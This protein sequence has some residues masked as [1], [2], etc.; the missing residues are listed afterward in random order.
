MNLISYAFLHRE[1]CPICEASNSQRLFEERFTEGETWRFICEYYSDR[2]PREALGK[3]VFTVS[4]CSDCGFVYQE[5]I[6]DNEGMR[7]LYEEWI[8]PEKSRQKQ[9]A[10][11]DS[12]AVM[13][14]TQ[15]QTIGQLVDQSASQCKVLD[16]GMGWGNWC[17]MA[18]AHGF[19][20]YGLELSET[21]IA[22]AEK[23][24]V[25]VIRGLNEYEGA[26]NFVNCEQVL[27]H[28]PNP[29]DTLK[30][31]CRVLRPGGYTR[32]SVPNGSRLAAIIRNGK[33][34][35]GKDSIHPLEHL[36][37][38]SNQTLKACGQRAGLQVARQPILNYPTRSYRGLL[39]N[40]FLPTYLSRRS[41]NLYFRIEH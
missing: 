37:S 20:T 38:F 6:L 11:S 24:G 25:R 36:N 4:E 13:I 29:V 1:S 16:Y 26:F 32:V 39:R 28:V 34:K 14:A 5:N 2:I 19:E 23:M 41:T 10:S 12:N 8:D 40:R 17:R 33:W 21:R 3:E 27:E 9:R 7:V 15:V 22:S 31:I 30:A 18:Q 35:P